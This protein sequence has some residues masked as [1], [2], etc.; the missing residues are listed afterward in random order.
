MKEEVIAWYNSL[1]EEW[2]LEPVGG[3]PED[4]SS[5]VHEDFTLRNGEKSDL[6]KACA[7]HDLWIEERE[8]R[9]N[10]NVFSTIFE[11]MN[12][13]IFPGDLCFVAENANGEFSGYI[14]AFSVSASHLQ[15]SQLEIMP[16]YRGMGIGEALLSKLLDNVDKKHAYITIDLPAGHEYFSRVLHLENFK[17]CVQRYILNR[18]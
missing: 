2:G 18:N 4:T 10:D 6:E 3:E 13:F 1:R 16:E 7:L 12:P 17:P 11:G 8:K 5:L 15:I 14:S 9:E